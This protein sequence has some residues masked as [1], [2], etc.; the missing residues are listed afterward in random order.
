[1]P[2]SLG[3]KTKDPAD[4]L[5]YTIDYSTQLRR[6]TD[7]IAGST[8]TVPAGLTFNPAEASFSTTAATAWISGGTAGTDYIVTNRITT[9]EGRVYERSFTLRV[10]DL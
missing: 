2:T 9:T 8:W 1:M 4:R 5:D 6:E 3:T 7:T 10:K